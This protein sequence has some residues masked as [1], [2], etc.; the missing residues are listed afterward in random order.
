MGRWMK[1][2]AW[3]TWLPRHAP[4]MILALAV[5]LGAAAPAAAQQGSN[6]LRV[7]VTDVRG[8][9]TSYGDEVQKLELVLDN[10]GRLAMVHLV[11]RANAN[12]YAVSHVWY[13]LANLIAFEYQAYS[14]IGQG[15]I[16]YLR[17]IELPA[18]PTVLD[19]G[20]SPAGPQRQ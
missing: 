20:R 14:P 8:K 15:R 18:Q 3:A 9:D 2:L 7:V 1:T 4:A 13:N 12:V 11:L 10:D 16:H 6:H 17:A 19:S 5:L